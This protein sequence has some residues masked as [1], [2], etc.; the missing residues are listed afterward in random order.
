MYKKISLA[1]CKA[2]YVGVAAPKYRSEPTD[3]RIKKNH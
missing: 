3:V 1:N 2:Y